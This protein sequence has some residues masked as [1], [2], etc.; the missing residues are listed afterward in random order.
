[1]HGILT[2]ESFMMVFDSFHSM[3]VLLEQPNEVFF[4]E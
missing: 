2:A 4:F 1:M 3:I